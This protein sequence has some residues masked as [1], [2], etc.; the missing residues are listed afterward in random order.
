[1]KKEYKKN[2]GQ[3]FLVIVFTLLVSCQKEP[4][5]ISYGNDECDNC[6]M[7]ISDPKFGSELIN[8]KSKVYKFDS[9]ECLAAFSNL[10][11]QDDIHSMW[12]TDF[13]I[14]KKFINTTEAKFL[15]SENL[16]SPMGLNISAYS[17]Q[18][19]LDETKS[20]AGGKALS[21]KDVQ[22]YVQNMWK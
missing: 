12:V 9:I 10:Q 13:T 17:N 19:S 15:V 3:F 6:K 4:E 7:T 1:M 14:P 8:T 20:T 11:K 5:P 18:K 22:I 16:K 21:W 2:I